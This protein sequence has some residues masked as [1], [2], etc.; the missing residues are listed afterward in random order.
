M[1][2]PEIKAFPAPTA[3][4]TGG[5]EVQSIVAGQLPNPLL[6]T[7]RHRDPSAMAKAPANRIP[8][9][10][11]PSVVGWIVLTCALAWAYWAPMAMLIHRWWTEPDYQHG[12]L[13]PLFAL[14]LLWK[15]RETM[16][17]LSGQGSSWGIALVALAALM[18]W[19]GAYFYFG[20]IGA[21]SLV[22]CLAGI[23]LFVGGRKAL[24]W[25]GP[26]IVFLIFMVPAPG[27]FGDVL[28]N[29]LQRLGTVISTYALQTLGIPAVAQGNVILLTESEL[30][31]AEACSGLRMMML[32]VTVCVGAALL[33][34]WSPV[35][36]ILV[37]LSA[38]PIAIAANVLRITVTGILYETASHQ[39][40]ETLYH[41]LAGWLMMPLAVIL[42]WAEIAVFSKLVVAPA[43]QGNGRKKS[44]R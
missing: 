18:R 13:V 25:A 1:E 37:V 4:A 6:W 34:Q 8:L 20:L 36:K 9:P 31:V 28:S 7:P 22:P 27:L 42:L 41:D 23:V 24:R 40:A 44:T 15:R 10:S 16:P 19:T 2:T 39:V 26:S 43:G 3:F 33:M 38:V 5:A 11:S 12:F 35:K 30:G 17:A 14:F 32:F 29:P 21:L